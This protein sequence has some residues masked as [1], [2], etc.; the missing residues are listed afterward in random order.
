MSCGVPCR[1]YCHVPL[2]ISSDL[3]INLGLP[4]TESYKP[5]EASNATFLASSPVLAI[6]I[7]VVQRG[8][9]IAGSI[10]QNTH[11]KLPQFARWDKRCDF[12]VLSFY[13]IK[14][15]AIIWHITQMFILYYSV[16]SLK[17][18]VNKN[19]DRFTSRRLLDAKTITLI[20]AESL[21]IEPLE[22][23]CGKKMK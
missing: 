13:V 8:P 12:Q 2:A 11:R 1:A 3:F 22:P 6:I 4:P 15:W 14:T 16:L 17:H 18:T 7:Y 19:I 10:F 21:S 20:S 5:V 23:N 9:V